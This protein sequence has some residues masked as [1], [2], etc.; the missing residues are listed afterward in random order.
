[1][2]ICVKLENVMVVYYRTCTQQY[3]FIQNKE[4]MP[5][6]IQQARSQLSRNGGSFL[7]YLL[8]YAL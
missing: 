3:I 8:P 1:M 2:Y 7:T 4:I 6:A 5:N